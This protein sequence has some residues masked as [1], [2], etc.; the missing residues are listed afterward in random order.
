MNKPTRADLKALNEILNRYTVAD[1][2]DAAAYHSDQSQRQIAERLQCHSTVFTQWKNNEPKIIERL[3]KI[4][5][6]PFED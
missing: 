4:T 2:V 1:L 6:M 3:R 5:A